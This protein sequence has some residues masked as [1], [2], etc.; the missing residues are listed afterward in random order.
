[1]KPDQQAQML[2]QQQP[3]RASMMHLQSQQQTV[4][5]VSPSH[6]LQQEY[7]RRPVSTGGS[8]PLVFQPLAPAIHH[9][10]QHHFLPSHGQFLPAHHQQYQ[11]GAPPPPPQMMY[12][13]YPGPQTS[14]APPF[15]YEPPAAAAAPPAS[16]SSSTNSFLHQ[17]KQCANCGT[18][19]TPSW[20]R[21]PDGK[22]LLCNACGLYAKLH[23]R[24]RPFKLAEDGSVRVVRSSALYNS[25]LEQAGRRSQH[26]QQ[27]SSQPAPTK[28]CEQCG[29]E[30][31][32]AWRGG[33][34]SQV[35]CDTCCLF[36]TG[37]TGSSLTTGTAASA[38]ES[39]FLASLVSGADP[40][41]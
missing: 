40:I 19:N 21:C 7:Y 41:L 25:V 20:R 3:Q 5:M 31:A 1:M 27:Q 36:Y 10:H 30:E 13:F 37:R 33:R 9:H 16:M 34:T 22:D 15:F 38:S 35:L 17:P 18:C 28:P 32:T 24:P 39:S 2:H 11:H 26:Q 14:A 4:P 29:S 8:G 6:G 23:H 12:N